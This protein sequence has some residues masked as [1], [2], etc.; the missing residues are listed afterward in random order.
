[1]VQSGCDLD[2][3]NEL[4]KVEELQTLTVKVV[5]RDALNSGIMG[6]M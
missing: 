5:V 2:L 4:I 3:I 6:L 1:M